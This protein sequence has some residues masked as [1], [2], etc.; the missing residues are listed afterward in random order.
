[1]T[2][3]KNTIIFQPLSTRYNFRDLTGQVFHY[4]AVLGYAGYDKFT[5]WW[6]EC[7]CGTIGKI[8]GNSLLIGDS[9]SCG[10]Y[11]IQWSTKFVTHGETANGIQSPEYRTYNDAKNRCRNPNNV[12]YSDWGGRGI[13]FRFNSFKEFLSEI[14]RKPNAAYTLERINVNGHYEIGNVKWATRTEQ[15]RNTRRNH[16]I[17]VGDETHC[18]TEWTEIKQVPRSRIPE[19]LL[20]GWCETCA[21]TNPLFETCSHR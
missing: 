8:N 1:M 6:C 21:V 13:E 7:R 14:G 12:R 18:I 4:W 16:V 19:R 3:N 15:A 10:C 20:A 17:T 2:Y 9:Q 5:F 11:R